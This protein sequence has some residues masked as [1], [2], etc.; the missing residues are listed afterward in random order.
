MSNAARFIGLDESKVRIQVAVASG[1][2]YGE[3][4]EYGSIPNT[5]G[6]SGL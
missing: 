5:P 1:G 4:R 6:S 2:R 3:V